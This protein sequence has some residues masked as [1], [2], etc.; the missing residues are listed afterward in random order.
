ME[1]FWAWTD[2]DGDLQTVLTR[3][4]LLDNLMLYWLPGTGASAARLY[5]ESIRQVNQW[6]S[7]Q[8]SGT[9]DIP[10]GCTVFPEELQRPSRR[11]AARRFTNIVYWNEPPRGATSPHSSNRNSS[12]AK[13]ARS[14]ASS[15]EPGLRCQANPSGALQAARK[16]PDR[17][18]AGREPGREG[19]ELARART[20]FRCK[21][22]HPPMALRS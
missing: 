9:I 5:W 7:G 18:A 1:K 8:A 2:H 10:A 21:R 3:D 19:T 17:G 12:S 16:G 20:D 6:I 4:E 22:I 15:G 14:S 13:S 11:W